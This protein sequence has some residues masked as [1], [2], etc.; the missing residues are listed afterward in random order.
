MYFIKQRNTQ[1]HK[2]TLQIYSFQQGEKWKPFNPCC[3]MFLCEVLRKDLR[4]IYL[5]TTCPTTLRVNYYAHI[6]PG[7][8][9]ATF[10]IIT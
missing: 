2:H 7:H 8:I 6:V 9:R 1:P 4:L 3:E 10:Q 5:I